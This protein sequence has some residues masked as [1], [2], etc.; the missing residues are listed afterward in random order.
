M[1]A[2]DTSALMAIILDESEAERCSKVLEAEWI[3]LISA[4]TVAEALIVV[5]RRNVGAPDRWAWIRRFERHAR[6]RAPSRRGLCA[7][8]QGFASGGTEFRRLLRL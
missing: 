6:R 3:V 4:V 2:V 8:G 1:I 5:Q 7:M